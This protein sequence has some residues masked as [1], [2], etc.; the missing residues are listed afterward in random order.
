MRPWP[1]PSA[2]IWVVKICH[3]LIWPRQFLPGCELKYLSEIRRFTDVVF[4]FF[5][6]LWGR[7]EVKDVN[8][9]MISVTPQGQV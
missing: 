4:F 9:K 5:F 3:K 6:K 8:F 7:K 1:E 2:L